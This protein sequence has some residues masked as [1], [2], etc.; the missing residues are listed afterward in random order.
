MPKE[1]DPIGW[2]LLFTIYN[3]FKLNPFVFEEF[4]VKIVKMIDENFNEFD[5]TR[6]WRD[7][8]RDALGSYNIGTGSDKL[9]I[10]VALEA[11]CYHPQD[12][13]C[14]IKLTSRLISR[15]KH[16]EFGIFVTTSWI[17]NQAYKEIKQDKHP[18]LII[19]GLD[20][21]NILRDH[22]LGSVELLKSWLVS[23]FK[24]N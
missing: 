19:S 13:G 17:N 20:I 4:A 23:N 15:I 10:S 3:Y 24:L 14:G 8:G 1:N 18:I 11:K 9:S 22:D 2:N 6:P 16:R 21:I 5:L 12:N 7:G